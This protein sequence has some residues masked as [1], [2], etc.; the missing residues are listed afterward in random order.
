MIR[1][2]ALSFGLLLVTMVV[3]GSTYVVT[4][5]GLEELPPMRF[6]LLRFAVASALLVPVALLRGGLARL[7]RPVPWLTLA[8]MAFTGVGLYYVAFNLALTYTTASHGALVQSSIPAVTA[9]MAAVWLGE[10]LSGRRLLG[11]GLAVAGVLLVV[12]GG[13]QG[14][15]ARAPLAGTLLL[16]GSVLAWGAYTML[17]KRAAGAD[18]VAVTAIVTLLGTALLVP[19]AL[20][21]GGG[22][23][24][25]SITAGGW[26][27][28]VHLGA[29]GSA[30]AFLLYN[31]ALRDLEA[32]Q[33]GTFI[34]LVPVVGVACGVVFLGETV[35]PPSL[36]GGML[37]LAGVWISSRAATERAAPR[38]GALESRP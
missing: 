27:K 34:N 4:K 2:R 37:V 29:F 17:A 18:P 6:A 7:P 19:A 24:A 16:L 9:V 12:A 33:V 11:I 8:A 13:G 23:A 26:L 15:A 35:S 14:T 32:S 31:R 1:G 22:R 3:W 5:A 38:D 20:F 21:E 25:A 30:G 28:I 10:R 36:L